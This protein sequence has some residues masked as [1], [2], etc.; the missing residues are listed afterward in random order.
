MKYVLTNKGI[1]LILRGIAG[2]TITFSQ[3]QIGNGSVESVAS[4]TALGNPLLTVAIESIAVENGYADIICKFENSDVTTGFSRTEVGIFTQDPDNSAE[5]MLFAYGASD[6]SEADY[7]PASGDEILETQFE[8]MVF[9][10]T[11]ENVTAIINES[12]VYASKSYVDEHINNTENPHQVTAE[13]VGASPT[14]HTHAF[15]TITGLPAAYPPSTHTHAFSTI[16]GRPAAYPPSHDRRPARVVIGNSGAGYT[17]ADCD[18]LCDGTDDQTEINAA[19]A[20][21]PSLGGKIV[22]LDGAYSITANI[23][24]SK[25]N[26]ELCGTAGA[27]LTFSNNSYIKIVADGCSVHSL[28]L[29]G[30]QTSSSKPVLLAQNCT[31]PEI[32]SLRVSKGGIQID[33]CTNA[34]VRNNF[35]GENNGYNWGIRLNSG[36]NNMVTGNN[37]TGAY[38]CIYATDEKKLTASQNIADTFNECGISLDTCEDAVVTSNNFSTTVGGGIIGITSIDSTRTLIGNNNIN[39]DES[40]YLFACINISGSKKSMVIGNVLRDIS[41]HQVVNITSCTNILITENVLVSDY[42]T[43]INTSGS[44]GITQLNNY[45]YGL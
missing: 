2:D 12:L 41:A 1:N 44:S 34:I 20:A 45:G 32:F 6:E 28:I 38:C 29:A 21:L 31:K 13:Q 43:K 37:L 24:I 19:L 9:V 35:I 17:A 18:Y 39:M 22:L 3:I 25:A 27:K 42:A 33:T 23:M 40:G 11:T 15:S 8:L 14:G 5:N 10:G 16:T 30:T 26:A 7:I 4:A 36:N